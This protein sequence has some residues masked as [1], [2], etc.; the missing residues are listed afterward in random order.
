MRLDGKA[1][2]YEGERASFSIVTIGNGVVIGGTL[3]HTLHRAESEASKALDWIATQRDADSRAVITTMLWVSKRTG[4][5]CQEV[6]AT[7]R[8]TFRD[9]RG[10]A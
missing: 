2:T 7:Q 5:L 3:V 4:Q 10:A 1:T 9:Q 6:I 8:S